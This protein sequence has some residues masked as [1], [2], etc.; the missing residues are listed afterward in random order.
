MGQAI[1]SKGSKTLSD[2]TVVIDTSKN[3]G[4][5]INKWAITNAINDNSSTY[6][7]LLQEASITKKSYVSVPIAY[8]DDS[9]GLSFAYIPVCPTGDCTQTPPS[10][11]RNRGPSTVYTQFLNKTT[12]P[13]TNPTNPT[14]KP[15]NPTAPT[16][17][18]N[19]TA[20]TATTNPTA[21]TNPTNP[22]NPTAPTATTGTKVG[23]VEDVST[24]T[25]TTAPPTTDN[26]NTYLIIGGVVCCFCCLIVIIIAF[27][28][29]SSSNSNA[30]E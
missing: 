8:Y 27:F 11:T 26:T 4:K 19:P 29:M 12:T 20:P 15:T 28:L 24:P 22:T 30:E 18:T 7:D 17:T 6:V 23:A 14:T 25:V 16:A 1:S 2:G 9:E 13:P 3:L 10:N 5:Y 21:P